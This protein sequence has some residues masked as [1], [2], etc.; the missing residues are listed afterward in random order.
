MI[1]K[2]KNLQ[3]L[4]LICLLT[5]LMGCNSQKEDDIGFGMEDTEIG[6]T[7]NG[8]DMES[9]YSRDTD[10]D[11]G[12]E[13]WQSYYTYPLSD[14][15]TLDGV[16][17]L[18]R[19][20][21]TVTQVI[22]DLGSGNGIRITRYDGNKYNTWLG[23]GV[24][25]TD[26][27]RT[28]GEKLILVGSEWGN[29]SQADKEAGVIS[30]SQ[31]EL[32]GYTNISMLSDRPRTEIQEIQNIDISSVNGDE[33]AVNEALSST[34]LRYHTYYV[35]NDSFRPKDLLLTD[36]YMQEVTFSYYAETKY[37][38][39]N[40]SMGD[41]CYLGGRTVTDD[42]PKVSVQQTKEGYFILDISNLSPGLYAV[43]GY[44]GSY[45]VNII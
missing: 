45:V 41:P 15:D 44:S 12:D 42:T 43:E 8:S 22:G 7:E 10:A 9:D 37:S 32:L 6:D 36:Q 13:T 28:N 16:F 1:F 19:D 5:F 25:P 17:R 34:G 4:F 40:I 35:L 33:E 20:S 11:G 27:D 3:G 38:T 2:R 30:M 18:D 26:I 29:M 21:D 39:L 14:I 23:W 24:S 31:L